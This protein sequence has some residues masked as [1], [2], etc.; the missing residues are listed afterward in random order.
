LKKE[1]WVKKDQRN[2]Q[3]FSVF[4]KVQFIKGPKVE[5]EVGKNCT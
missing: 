3:S 5:S 4:D 2:V 1:K